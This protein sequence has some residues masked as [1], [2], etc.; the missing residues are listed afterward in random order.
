MV[1]VISTQLIEHIIHILSEKVRRN[2]QST[3]W[4]KWY[5]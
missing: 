3:V 4:Y 1:L 2:S 5:V